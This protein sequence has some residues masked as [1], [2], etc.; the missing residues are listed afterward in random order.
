MQAGDELA[1]WRRQ[2]VEAVW[3]ASRYPQVLSAWIIEKLGAHKQIANRLLEP[4]VWTQQV[5][6]STEVENFFWLRDHEMAEPHFRELA[7]Q[8]HSD[9]KR[10]KD[11]FSI[12]KETV[13]VAD[14]RLQVLRRGE[15]H[16]PFITYEDKR[17][18]SLEMLKRISAARCARTS[19]LLPENGTQSD[20]K[21]DLELFDRLAVREAGSNDPRH[22]SPL[23]HQ[24]E[25]IGQGIYIGNFKGF[26]QFRKEIA[27][28]SGPQQ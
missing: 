25:A 23:E 14:H 26:R 20:L 24:A 1:G 12:F 16:L 5:L 17:N 8:M 28:E 19:Y 7:R 15:W 22:L 18:N 9:A 21:R 3:K 13:S 11:L 10:A 4:Y 6:S 27:D 2:A